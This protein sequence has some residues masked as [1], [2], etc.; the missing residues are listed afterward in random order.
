MIYIVLIIVGAI[1][2]SSFSAKMSKQ[3]V[4]KEIDEIGNKIQSSNG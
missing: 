1:I 2:F 4:K 3:Q